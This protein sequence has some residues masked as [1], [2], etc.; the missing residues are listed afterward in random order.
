MSSF[1]A[2][3]SRLKKKNYSFSVILALLPFSIVMMVHKERD[4]AL[5][6]SYPKERLEIFGRLVVWFLYLCACVCACV[7]MCISLLLSRVMS[8]AHLLLLGWQLWLKS[9]SAITCTLAFVLVHTIRASGVTWM[10]VLFWSCWCCRRASWG[11]AVI[12]TWM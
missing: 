6:T 8:Q 9:I 4:M 11:L 3:R 2:R 1:Q 5:V 10:T 7:L 12:A